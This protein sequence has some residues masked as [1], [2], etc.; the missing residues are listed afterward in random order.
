M[1]LPHLNGHAKI[2]DQSDTDTERVWATLP[3]S[4][5]AEIDDFHHG[6]R[7]RNRAVAVAELIKL[8]LQA[9]GWRSKK[10]DA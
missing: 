6:K 7:F 9:Q 2:G 3:K 10:P 8:G 5:V 1:A 4:L